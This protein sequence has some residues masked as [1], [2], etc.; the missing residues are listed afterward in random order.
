M[1]AHGQ[2]KYNEKSQEMWKMVFCQWLDISFI[3]C[4]QSVNGLDNKNYLYEIMDECKNTIDN[5]VSI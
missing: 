1:K 4:L 2:H 3:K 5:A